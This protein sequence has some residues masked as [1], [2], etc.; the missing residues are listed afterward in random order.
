MI[1]ALSDNIEG[2]ISSSLINL[3]HYIAEYY[4]DEFVSA[5][6][7][8]GLTLSSSLSAIETTSIM[9]DVGINI[10]QLRVLLRIND[11]ILVLNCLNL[12][13]K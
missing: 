12:S 10:S 6:G 4:E 9:N 13:P 11:I 2:K 1:V 7:D 3:C 8:S 5:A